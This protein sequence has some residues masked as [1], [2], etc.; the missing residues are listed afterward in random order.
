LSP[1]EREVADLVAQGLTNREIAKRLFISERT[2]DGHLEHVREKLDVNTRAQIATW[3]VRQETA[4]PVV[5][6][7][8]PP[9]SLT[10]AAPGQLMARP[11]IWVATALVLAV[12]AA[13]VGLLRLTAAPG[14][15]IKTIAGTT[16]SNS[17]PGGNYTGDG[18]LATVAQL[19]RPSDVVVGTDG[20]VYIADYGN[21]VVRAVAAGVITSYTG[22]WSRPQARDGDIADTVW[23][24]YPSN[25]ALDAAG[26][27]YILTDMSGVLEVW[28]VRARDHSINRV[29]SI[30]PTISYDSW[31]SPAGGLAIARDGTLYIA[32]R[33][34]N[35]VWRFAN[36]EKSIYAGTGDGAFSGD[37]GAARSAMLNWP[38]GLALDQGGNLFIADTLNSRIRKVDTRGT[39][40]TVAGDGTDGDTGDGGPATQAHLSIPYGVAVGADGTLVIAD[41]GNNRLRLVTPAN[42]IVALAGSASGGFSGDDGPAIAAQLRAPGGVAFD[43]NGDLFVADTWNHRV[44]ELLR[45]AP[46]H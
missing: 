6:S 31:R 18:D 30:G 11:R 37:G 1:R 24:G 16:S 25:L 39:I 38:T 35:L 43:A 27:L 3:V 33:A 17:F 44:R 29:V 42:Q 22:P 46:S 41:T 36:G 34:H 28:V 14:P 19:R 40:T 5:A 26:N 8:P 12:L 23:I 13:G 2:V 4:P 10:P 9:G 45:V 20:T 15:T 7:P 21:S 32:D